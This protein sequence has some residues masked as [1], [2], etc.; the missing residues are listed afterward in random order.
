[1]EKFTFNTGR[2]YSAD[3]Q[4]I[5]IYNIM[6]TTAYCPILGKKDGPVTL[7]LMHDKSRGIPRTYDF[8]CFFAHSRILPRI[9]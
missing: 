7:I 3:G 9:K 4:I 6:E 1:M 5:D 2:E 8:F